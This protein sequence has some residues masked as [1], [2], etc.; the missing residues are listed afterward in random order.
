MDTENNKFI[1]LLKSQKE[2]INNNSDKIL[3]Y[4]N[5]NLKIINN[6]K[7]LEIDNDNNF[8][9]INNIYTFIGTF[10]NNKN[11]FF[12]IDKDNN[13][14]YDCKTGFAATNK[15]AIPRRR[16]FLKNE[17]NNNFNSINYVYPEVSFY[18]KGI[19]NSFIPLNKRIIINNLYLKILDTNIQD[20]YNVVVDLD[21][22]DIP[23]NKDYI[24]VIE[25]EEKGYKLIPI[26]KTD[27]TKDTPTDTGTNTGGKRKTKRSKK[28]KRKTKKSKR[29]SKK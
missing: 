18:E 10:I 8:I 23:F 15:Y 26:N 14:H 6:D 7:N 17:K 22:K 19:L 28:S 4:N 21:D 5:T 13:E 16:F 1:E 2:Y 12:C 24:F 11:N 29:K 9:K 20:P 3:I 27:I 25:K